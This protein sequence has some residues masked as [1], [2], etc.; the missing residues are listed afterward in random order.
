MPVSRLR[1]SS[2]HR[3][4]GDTTAAG[5][6]LSGLPRPARG[7]PPGDEGIAIAPSPSGRAWPLLPALRLDRAGVIGVL[8]EAFVVGRADELLNVP[9]ELNRVRGADV[10]VKG[11]L[12]LPDLDELEVIRRGLPGNHLEHH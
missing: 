8:V 2:I 11:L 10:G 4:F 1:H 12:V 3:G 6:F 5:P 9:P 7:P